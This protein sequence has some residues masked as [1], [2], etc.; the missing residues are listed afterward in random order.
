MGKDDNIEPAKLYII[1]AFML[2]FGTCNTIVMKAQDD[3]V[4]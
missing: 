1:M 3:V 4:T 2:I